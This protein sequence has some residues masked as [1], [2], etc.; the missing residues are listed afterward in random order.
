MYD[1][2]GLIASNFDD[3]DDDYLMKIVVEL[4]ISQTWGATCIMQISVCQPILIP[5]HCLPTAELEKQQ[6]KNF[7][8]ILFSKV[9]QFK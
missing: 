9:Y 8:S 1:S 4:L 7:Q 6:H 3:D 2:L 5:N